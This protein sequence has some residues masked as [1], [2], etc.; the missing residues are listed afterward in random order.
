MDL[1][2]F[3][4]E[5]YSAIKAEFPALVANDIPQ[6][7]ADNALEKFMARVDLVIRVGGELV[8]PELVDAGRG[9]SAAAMLAEEQTKAIGRLVASYK[10]SGELAEP[11]IVD[12][13]RKVGRHLEQMEKVVLPLVRELIPTAVREDLGEIALDYRQDLGSGAVKSARS[14]VSATIS[15]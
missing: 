1:L 12:I 5:E 8:I 9:A 7:L 4:K 14:K 11:K 2:H 13:F 6:I 3:M 10:K 15:A